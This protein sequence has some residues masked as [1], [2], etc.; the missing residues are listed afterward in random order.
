MKY[1]MSVAASTATM[2]PANATLSSLE[3]GDKTTE[4]DMAMTVTSMVTI[5]PN[6]AQSAFLKTFSDFFFLGIMLR[7]IGPSSIVG[8]ASPSLVRKKSFVKDVILL[9]LTKYLFAIEFC[10]LVH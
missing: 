4:S 1:L 3:L 6:I 10:I 9:K 7:F 5:M 8:F 2:K